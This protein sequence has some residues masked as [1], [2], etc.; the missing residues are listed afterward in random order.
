MYLHLLYVKIKKIWD[1]ISIMLNK[2]QKIPIGTQTANYDNFKLFMNILYGLN[3]S[4]N[5]LTIRKAEILKIFLKNIK[6]CLNQFS[7]VACPVP[8]DKISAYHWTTC[9]TIVP[10]LCRDLNILYFLTFFPTKTDSAFSLNEASKTI[11]RVCWELFSDGLV[12][13]PGKGHGHE[14]SFKHWL[15][16]SILL[17]KRF[18]F[19]LAYSF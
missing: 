16:Y 9:P 15:R 1:G 19:L 12:S 8:V 10:W 4:K 6:F 14:L 2:I 3:S 5:K 18:M 17:G 7:S 13:R 11:I